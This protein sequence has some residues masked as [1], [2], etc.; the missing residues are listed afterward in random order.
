[1]SGMHH[2]LSGKAGSRLNIPVMSIAQET[3]N[4]TNILGHLQMIG[5]RMIS[6]L[7]Q[8]FL[9]FHISVLNMI[10]F[11]KKKQHM[12]FFRTSCLPRR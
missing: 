4:Y 9:F 10:Y 1:M 8:A 7:F 11:D 2:I 12:L 3:T 6:F 5:L